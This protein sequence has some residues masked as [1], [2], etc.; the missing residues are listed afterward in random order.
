MWSLECLAGSDV[1]AGQG[2]AEVWRMALPFQL[3]A[4][5]TDCSCTGGSSPQGLLEAAESGSRQQASGQPQIQ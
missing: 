1:C 4:G 2:G 3:Q 5:H